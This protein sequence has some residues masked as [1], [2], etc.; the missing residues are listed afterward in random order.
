MNAGIMRRNGRG[1]GP[2]SWGPPA[3]DG[4]ESGVAGRRAWPW[5]G[6]AGDIIK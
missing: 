1:V 5:S 4:V 2:P 6:E 3:L